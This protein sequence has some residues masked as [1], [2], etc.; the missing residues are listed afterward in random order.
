MAAALD[1]LAADCG[2][3]LDGDYVEF[4]VYLGTSMGAAVRA[5]DRA[6]AAPARFFGFDSF[7]G[8]PPESAEDGWIPGDFATTREVAEW[9]LRRQGV[10]ERVTLIK[11]WFDETCTEETTAIFGLR[12]ILV[13]MIDCDTYGSSK[14]ALAYVEPMLA[15]SSLVVF[16]DWYA[17]NPDGTKVE[18]QRRVFEEF[19]ARR[20]DIRTT[21]L[22]RVGYHGQSFL[23][24]S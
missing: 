2:G 14:T 13:A 18:G 16:D 1:R 19:L 9:H 22:G 21:D 17:L 5:F 20:P 8:L 11:G 23:I 12:K 3:V 4:G 24:S 7:A 15:P 6:G 10:L